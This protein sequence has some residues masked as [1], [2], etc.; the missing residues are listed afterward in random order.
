[1]PSSSQDTTQFTPCK[2]VDSIIILWSIISSLGLS[3]TSLSSALLALILYIAWNS[4]YIIL[5]MC[6]LAA[7][8]HYCSN[9]FFHFN[10]S[11]SILLYLDYNYIIFF[12]LPFF[13]CLLY[14]LLS[15]PATSQFHSLLFF[16]HCCYIY[17]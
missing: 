5:D 4:L 12:S 15:N 7:H 6:T 14:Y 3:V 8:Y 10:N 17:M 11:F 1:M 13:L 16:N 2:S 9:L